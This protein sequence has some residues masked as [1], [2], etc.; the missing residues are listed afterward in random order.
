M[1]DFRLHRLA[2]LVTVVTASAAFCLLIGGSDLLM[3]GDT[4]LGAGF[5]ALIG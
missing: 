2:M 3:T 5:A 4:I 1:P